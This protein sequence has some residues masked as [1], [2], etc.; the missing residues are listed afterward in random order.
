MSDNETN[1]QP[2]NSQAN[3]DANNTNQGNQNINNGPQNATSNN[4][5]RVSVK[6]PPFW[7]ADP[8]LWFIQLEAQFDLASITTDSTRY[9]YVLSAIDTDILTQVTDFLI[10][11]P[12]NNK[13][14][15]IKNR[16]ISMYSETSEK[17]L[18]KLLSETTLGDKKPSQ[19]LNEMYNLG[20]TTVPAEVIKT[21]WMQHLPAQIQSILTTST[22]SLENLSKMADKIAEIEQPKTY[23]YEVQEKDHS[24][25]EAVQK[26]SAQVAEMKMER[27]RSR[28]R[29]ECE[30]NRRRSSSRPTN[31]T[32]EATTQ[33]CWYHQKF[34]TKARKCISPCAFSNKGN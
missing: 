16:L 34:G 31:S 10:N 8:R 17:K 5:E 27:H 15:G 13:Y 33:Q 29:C 11:T 1:N 28:D 18:K 6:V 21:L 22:D 26:L 25:T 19:L 4:V 24:L 30:H 23:A 7:K 3:I 9:N 2:T 12:P 14:I 32:N 20:G